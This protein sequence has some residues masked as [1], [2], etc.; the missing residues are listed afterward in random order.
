MLVLAM[1]KALPSLTGVSAG[2][3]TDT[4]M[5]PGRGLHFRKART[6]PAAHLPNRVLLGVAARGQRQGKAEQQY[7]VSPRGGTAP[8]LWQH[9]KTSLEL[10]YKPEI[11]GSAL[12]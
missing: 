4:R 5:K 10:N 1:N 12:L 11:S 3:Q 2:K 7:A 8:Q 9:G 6:A